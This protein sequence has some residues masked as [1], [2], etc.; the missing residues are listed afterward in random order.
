MYKLQYYALVR[1][2]KKIKAKLPIRLITIQ[3]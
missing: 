3:H 1:T 2:F